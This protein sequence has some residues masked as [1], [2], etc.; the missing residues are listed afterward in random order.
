MRDYEGAEKHLLSL[1][2]SKVPEEYKLVGD[3]F[4]AC[5]YSELN[6]MTQL[7]S[8][9]ETMKVHAVFYQEK[10]EF[11]ELFG[12]LCQVCEKF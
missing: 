1:K 12:H 8:L 4:L 5:A 10:A 9:V 6:K 7:K 11:K 2:Y 3:I